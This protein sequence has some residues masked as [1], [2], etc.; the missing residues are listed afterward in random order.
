MY[1]PAKDKLPVIV[2]EKMQWTLTHLVEKCSKLSCNKAATILYDVCLGLQY[3]H[4]RTPPIMHRDLT[5]NNI[6]LCYHYRAKI[7]DLG[8][9]RTLQTADGKLT[10]APGTLVFM[11]PECLGD[12][13][14]YD[15]SL[16]IFSFGGIILYIATQQWPT[17]SPWMVVDPNTDKKVILTSEVQR[18]QQYLDN[19]TGAYADL[20]LL[21]TSCL[22]DNPKNRPLV[23]EVL[24]K[25]QH[26]KKNSE[27]RELY[28]DIW[29]EDD[30]QLP[31]E[32][33]KQ[34]EQNQEHCQALQ[35]Q[36]E[37]Q[38]GHQEEQQNHQI[39]QDQNQQQEQTQQHEQNL[40]MKQ[41]HQQKSIQV[42][43]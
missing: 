3:L 6:L 29:S 36:K 40:M 31:S 14:A 41:E 1:Y 30:E 20:K 18:R 27:K 42:A 25:I 21:V 39:D 9:A 32:S 33:Q 34:L 19:M 12:K 8:V 38:Q 7:S 5:P 10:Q 23:T 43:S 22:D 37:L 35:H 15:L 26:L 13:P 17:P 28:V 24:T 2:M 16:D 4:S 11:P